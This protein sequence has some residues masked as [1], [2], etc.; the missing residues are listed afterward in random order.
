MLMKA[1]IVEDEPRVRKGLSEM[2]DW[3]GIGFELA[4]T[5]ANGKE[6]LELFDRTSPDLVICDIRMPVMD[7]LAMAE[8]VLERRPDVRIVILSG[9]DEFEYAQRCLYLGVKSFLLKPVG[10]EQLEEEL[11]KLRAK[12]LKEREEHYVAAAFMDKFRTQLPLLR[13]AFLEDW[14]NGPDRTDRGLLQENIEFLDIPFHLDGRTSVAVFEL[15]AE[16]GKYSPNDIRLLQ[17]GMHNIAEELL[18]GRGIVYARGNGQTVALYQ[19]ERHEGAEPFMT[20]VERAKHEIARYLK[21]TVTVGIGAADAEAVEAPRQ[22]KAALHALRLKWTVGPGVILHEGLVL[23]RSDRGIYLNE[24]DRELV[25]HCVE[26]GDRKQLEELLL[27]YF[28]SAP[29]SGLPRGNLR[30]IA[31]QFAGLYA[32]LVQRLGKRLDETL[33]DEEMMRFR[34]PER[35][36]GAEDMRIWWT[37]RFEA[38]CSDFEGFRTDQKAKLV[39]SI[40]AF[41]EERI[42]D[43]ISREEAA[44]HVHINVSYLSRIF[45]EATGESFSEYV[46]RKKIEKAIHLLK[47]DDAMVYEVADRLGYHDP[48]YFAR[49]F[50]KYTGKTPSDFQK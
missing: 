1:I 37:A 48:S 30:E 25:V 40:E 23:P 10:K 39:R 36:R 31:F 43:N 49:I 6:G 17:F 9:Y 4:G 5:A 24:T 19:T 2:V 20:W 14:L 44:R 8:A 45:K 35:F 26:T 21:A 34:E 7:G 11:L 50:K 27:R 22:F 38:L 41:V 16:E 46:L 47:D 32:A 18:E 3:E 13:A 28:N 29:A 33:S 12:W 42:M 15:D